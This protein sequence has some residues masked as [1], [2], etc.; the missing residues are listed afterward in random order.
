MKAF[1]SILV[2]FLLGIITYSQ[3]ASTAWPLTNPSAGGT[4]QNVTVSGNV[5]GS[6]EIL[7][8][9]VIN[10]YGGTIGPLGLVMQR[11]T[12]TDGSWP[13]ETQYLNTRYLEF[14]LSPSVNNTLVVDSVVLPLGSAGGGNMRAEIF[15]S[16]DNFATS[17]KLNF[18]T[19]APPR[20]S[21][22]I[23]SYALSV[24]INQGQSLSVRV[25]PFYTT[26]S[27]GKYLCAQNVVIYGTTHAVPIPASV[28]WPLSSNGTP[29]VSGLLNAENQSF[30]GNLYLYGYNADG[31]RMTLPGGSWP[32][33]AIPD[34]TRYVQYKI[35]PQTGGTFYLDS[36]AFKLKAEFTNY[37]R[38]SVYFSKEESFNTK[39]LLLDTA[40]NSSNMISFGFN[41]ADTVLT[42]QS[43]Y[44]RIFP[45]NVN[46]SG[47]PAWKL[48]DVSSVL[49]AGRTVGIAVQLPTVTTTIATYIST[50]FATSGG[51]ITADGGGEITAR[52]VC[53]GINGNPTISD[54]HT[55]DGTG[56]GLF[57]SSIT[58]LTPGETYHYRA[59]A[60]NIAGTA[61]G[62]DYTFAAL[63]SVVPPT[64]T[65]SAVSSIQVTTAIS[66]GNVTQWGGASVT[67]KG[68]CW[69]T[70]GD[71]TIND[72]FTNDGSGLGS[73]TS[74]ITGLSAG[75]P[76]Y[77]RAY[78]TNSAGTGYGNVQTFT[79]QTPAPD[80]TK[81]VAQDG[82]GDYLTV[83]AAFR[84]VPVNYTGKWTI[85]VKKGIY[86]E[87]DT[88]AAGKIN[89][90]L[91]GEHRDSTII[92]YDDYADRYG[93]GNPGTSGS[94]TIAI[95][96]SD[97]VAKNITF[98]NTYSPQPGVSGTQA[99]A[100]R[101]NGDRLEFINCKILGFQDTYYTWGGSGTGRSYHKNCFIEG[102]VDFIFGRYIA[103]FDSC[104]IQVKR[105]N[106]TITA[107]STDLASQYGYV[108]RNCTIL[109]DA[110]GYDGNP[111]TSFYL[112]RPWQASPRTVF[113]NCYEPAS[114]NPSGWL[115]WNVT[116]ALYGEYNC[117]GPGSN[118]SQRVAWS[119]QLNDAAANSH[120]LTNIFARNAASSP[121]ILYDWM[122]SSANN[123]LPLP[124]ELASFNAAVHG[125]SVTL[126]WSTAQEIRNVGWDI[127]RSYSQ[128]SNKNLNWE[129]IGFV[130]GSGNSSSSLSYSFVDEIIGRSGKYL[131]RLKQIDQDGSAAYSNIIEVEIAI[132]HRFEL[133]Q[134]FPN[135]FNPATTIRYDIPVLSDVQ[136]K[137]YD[138]LGNLVTNLINE[139]KEAGSYQTQFDGM[140]LSSGVYIY[141]I[142]TDKFIQTKKMMLIK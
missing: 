79:T 66:G 128:S 121:L 19:L 22:T 94:F 114:L 134:N 101:T 92:T 62:A 85:F 72:N 117:Y 118:T 111:I 95:D 105:N 8:N 64:V 77:V 25:F 45:Y 119:S 56:V 140:K 89:V 103:V 46:P 31:A 26:A 9:M 75:T 7:S 73:F 55:S 135:P 139:T 39:T 48:M 102:T 132:P 43:F 110:V 71:P 69:N 81:I 133:Y 38:A 33:N 78:A 93:S 27:T 125:N 68:V 40:L 107:A 115:A 116:P 99:V 88:L 136:I 106:G 47:D 57:T 61:Y 113:L 80:V 108:F 141:Q 120:V 50:T 20:D 138:L 3:S 30:G 98:Q 76:Y 65:T 11:T 58:V 63:T 14:K 86:Y 131:Y 23:Y 112:G 17:T 96:A 137:I 126:E 15:Y 87:K 13:G 123:E 74:G 70:T 29:V 36:I 59:Y 5:T 90:I 16:T 1:Y 32:Y 44:L 60:T 28:L 35:S 52:G 84:D 109:A 12:T 67:A 122:P 91:I 100:L 83:Q 2:F 127:E 6:L 54:S 18:S 97:F 49:V 41:I 130:T 42:G 142:T 10:S 21:Y 34:F 82:S 129:K 37:L 53:W 24:F 104:T 124:V 51:N 4:G